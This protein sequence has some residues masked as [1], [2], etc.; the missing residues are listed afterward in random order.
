[1]SPEVAAILE[2]LGTAG[3]LVVGSYYMIKYFMGQLARKDTRLDDITDRFVTATREQT[4]AIR[5]FISEQQRTQLIMATA[6]DKLTMAVGQ[7]EERRQ[8]QRD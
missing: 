8:S 1:M 7:L 6:I 5:D 2:R 4:A 3:V